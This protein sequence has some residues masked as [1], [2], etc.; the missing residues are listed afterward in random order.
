[1]SRDF[2]LDNFSS[3][4][5]D[6]RL[7][8]KKACGGL[9]RSLWETYSAMANT[10]GGVIICGV[11]E[12]E[13]HS[14]KTSGLKDIS[15]LKK[16][17]WDT[18]N[19]KSKVNINLIK[20]TDVEDYTIDGDVIFVVYV[21]RAARDIK[22]VYLNNDLMRGTY[23]RNWEGDYH[24]TER[25][26]KSMLRDQ[27]E[28]SQDMKVLADKKIE[29]FNQDSIRA[30]RTR[31]EGKHSGH[32]WTR[33]SDDEFLIMIGAADD[34]EDRIHPTS[35]GLLMFGQ[36][37]RIIRE[38]PEFFLDYR[39]K[40]DP[41]IRWT[42]RIESQSGDWSGNVFDFFTRVSYKLTVDLKK[43]FRTDGLY[44]IDE[45]AAHEAVREALCNC[46][47]N[48]DFFQPWSVVIEKY[49]DRIILANPGTI[50]TGK[51]QM[52]K[53]GISQPRNKNMFKMFNLIGI[54]E[55]AGSG[56]PDIYSIW[57]ELGYSTPEVTE[58]FGA[59]VPD[60]TILTLPLIGAS[61]E[62]DTQQRKNTSDEILHSAIDS[63]LSIEQVVDILEFCN[64]AKSRAEIQEHCGFK[65][66][67]YF[68]KT[69]LDP[70]IKGGQLSL[71]VPET[72]T[73]PGQK[74][75]RTQQLKKNN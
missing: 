46:L 41:S 59:G 26:I 55:H 21:P 53:G 51:K 74:Y 3:Y 73:H 30:Y 25:E 12:N 57:S 65:S 2:D 16:V 50:I 1:M 70:L 33:I 13:D 8:V 4:R 20:E 54:G 69:V 43:P 34:S 23:K 72:L 61:Q 11:E 24:C 14:W 52:L 49:P 44:R 35:A 42:D 31:F 36:E 18:I 45:T 6:N 64:T 58:Q 71:T 66:P 32:P 48:T 28:I 47:C 22:P 15:D 17:F 40:L 75:V 56:V 68:K 39:E 62:L 29:D 9:P 37:Y 10:Y 5:E 63:K 19:N 7:E 27:S 60:R 67:S 38:Y